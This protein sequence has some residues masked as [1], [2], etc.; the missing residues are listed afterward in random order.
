ME[1][2]IIQIRLQQMEEAS[3]IVA[4]NAEVALLAAKCYLEMEANSKLHKLKLP[5]LFDAIVYAAGKSLNAEILTGDQPSGTC[6]KRCGLNKKYV[7]TDRLI[8][9]RKATWPPRCV[10]LDA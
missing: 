8:Q 7:V 3:N 1:D 4:L 9:R 2:K 6:Q 5:G 10:N